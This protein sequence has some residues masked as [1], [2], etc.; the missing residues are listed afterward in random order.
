MERVPL[1]EPLAEPAEFRRRAAEIGLEVVLETTLRAVPDGVHLHLRKQGERS[2]VL[3]YTSSPTEGA[4]L[5][6]H[7]NRHKPWVDEA[8]R[9]LVGPGS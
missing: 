8:V 3:E 1:S 9:R 7:K 4:W 6:W 2:G 5:S